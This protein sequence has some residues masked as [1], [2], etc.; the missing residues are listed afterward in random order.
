MPFILLALLTLRSS[1]MQTR[2]VNTFVGYTLVAG[3]KVGMTPDQIGNRIAYPDRGL[4]RP[5]PA[6]SMLYI[7]Y[8]RYDVLIVWEVH[9]STARDPVRVLRWAGKRIVL[10]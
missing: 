10:K 2:V 3:A 7:W 4:Q 1:E 9:N 8:D 6:G 5:D